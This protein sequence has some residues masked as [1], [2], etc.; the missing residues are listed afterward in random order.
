MC[1]SPSMTPMISTPILA[2][3]AISHRHHARVIGSRALL[4]VR[5]VHLRRVG[6]VE[7]EDHPP[8]SRNVAVQGVTQ[9][10]GVLVE[11]G[12]LVQREVVEPEEHA[13]GRPAA[14]VAVRAAT[15]VK[16]RA[17]VRGLCPKS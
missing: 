15:Y 6:Q 8:D 13:V 10:D 9:P 17:T 2:A 3:P 1:R 12:V 5:P 7:N 14:A 11:L 16:G 4:F